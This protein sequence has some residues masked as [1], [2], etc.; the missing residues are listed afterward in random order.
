LSE[1]IEGCQQLYGSMGEFIVNYI[2]PILSG[3]T[4]S[5]IKARGCEI[6]AVYKYIEIPQGNLQN[7]FKFIYT[8]LTEVK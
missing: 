7:I 3:N 4:S 5:I 1:E 8:C 6:I 2:L